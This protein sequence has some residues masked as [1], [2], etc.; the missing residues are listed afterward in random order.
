MDAD[1]HVLRRRVAAY[2]DRMQVFY[3]HLW[4]DVGVRYGFWTPDTRSRADAIRNMDREVAAALDVPRRG[5]VLDAGCGVG[6]TAVHLAEEHGH[7]VIGITISREQLRRARRHAARCRAR[8]KPTFLLADYTCTGFAAK[9]FDGIV[10]IESV[11]YA[12]PKLRFAREAFRLLR[13]G[14]RL[15]VMD[16]FVADSRLSARDVAAYRRFIDGFAVPGLSTPE[17]FAADLEHAGFTA[18]GWWDRRADIMPSTW[19]I[20]ALSCLGL[21]LGGVPSALGLAP[22]VWTKHA[23]AGLCQ[24]RLFREGVLKYCVFVARRPS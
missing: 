14:G 19:R 6:G 9:T 18:V 22:R 17:D 12:Q 13:P 15:V 3:T 1:A 7:D 23:L 5:R 24:R 2:Y 21:L 8:V 11:C 10:G 16:G 4:S 20:Q